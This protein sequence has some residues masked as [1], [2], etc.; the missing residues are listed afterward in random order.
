[1]NFGKKLFFTGESLL[2][3]VTVCLFGKHFME[4]V[5]LV[6]TVLE[7]RLKI[8][9][10]RY[11]YIEDHCIFDDFRL[12]WM[13]SRSQ[14]ALTGTCWQNSLVDRLSWRTPTRPYSLWWKSLITMSRSV[15]CSQT[16]C[17]NKQGQKWNLYWNKVHNDLVFFPCKV[18]SC[19]TM[20]LGV[21]E[22]PVPLGFEPWC[23]VQSIGNQDQVVDEY[24]RRN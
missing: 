8:W 23:T 21:A 4:G 13:W 24:F 12:D 1:M 5:K 2:P 22:V 18:I 7:V 9:N 14:R 10:V 20:Y 6:Q 3:C 19:K 11:L 17:S 15:N 16:F